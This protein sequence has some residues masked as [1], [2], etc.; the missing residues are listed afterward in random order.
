MLA[1]IQH[2]ITSARG[3]VKELHNRGRKKPQTGSGVCACLPRSVN[4][5]VQGFRLHLSLRQ[6]HPIRAGRDIVSV[7]ELYVNCS[8]SARHS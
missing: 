2:I 7:S 8:L 5:F 6:V 3:D 1:Q 4:T